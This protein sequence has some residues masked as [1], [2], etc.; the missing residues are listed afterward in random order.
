MWDAWNAADTKGHFW[1]YII[2]LTYLLS[3]LVVLIGLNR[4]FGLE[5][6]ELLLPFLLIAGGVLWFGAVPWFR[7]LHASP[8]N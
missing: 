2:L 6:A 7:R 1:K 4:L 5:G 8:Q 3:C